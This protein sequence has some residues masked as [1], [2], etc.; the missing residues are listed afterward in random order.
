MYIDSDGE[1][2]LETREELEAFSNEA[3]CLACRADART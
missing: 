3:E 2:I 1:T